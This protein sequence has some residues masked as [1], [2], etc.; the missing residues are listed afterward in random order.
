MLLDPI[1]VPASAIVARVTLL[2]LVVFY[3]LIARV[4]A[5]CRRGGVIVFLAHYPACAGVIET[6]R[7]ATLLF[8]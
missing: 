1:F 8:N 3:L 5:A 7:A 2:D 6:R 4:G